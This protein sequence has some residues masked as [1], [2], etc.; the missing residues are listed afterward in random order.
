MHSATRTIC[1]CVVV[2]IVIL[3]GAFVF[4][5]GNAIRSHLTATN[6]ARQAL[7]NRLAE[8]MP[9]SDQY[10][11]LRETV[12]TPTPKPPNEELMRRMGF[13]SKQIDEI[14]DKAAATKKSLKS[15]STPPN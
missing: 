7:T 6:R 11:E 14:R 12:P 9:G 4:F 5:G 13:T 3:A 8:P 15:K 1:T 2:I 10:S